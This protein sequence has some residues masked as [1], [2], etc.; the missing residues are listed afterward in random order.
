MSAASALIE[1]LD[2]KPADLNNKF[3]CAVCYK[4]I[5]EIA[6][7]KRTY[8]KAK[9]AMEEALADFAQ[10]T[11]PTSCLASI[12]RYLFLFLFPWPEKK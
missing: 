11:D 8:Y 10:R 1:Y 5:E 2:V 6:K 7:T 3:L 9:T 4:Q 12:V